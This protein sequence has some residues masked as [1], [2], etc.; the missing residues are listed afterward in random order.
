MPILTDP[1]QPQS[2]LLTENL[3]TMHEIFDVFAYNFRKYDEKEYF[4]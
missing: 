3:S 4:V 1:N 2:H